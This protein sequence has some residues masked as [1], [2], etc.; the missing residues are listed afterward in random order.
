MYE[1]VKKL[2]E[3]FLNVRSGKETKIEK[4]L[5]TKINK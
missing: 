1:N 2:H 4:K 3:N 5:N